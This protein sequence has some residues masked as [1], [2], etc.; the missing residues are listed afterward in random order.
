MVSA[1]D[2]VLPTYTAKPAGV[3][4]DTVTTPEPELA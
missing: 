4:G 1:S 2:R 3:F